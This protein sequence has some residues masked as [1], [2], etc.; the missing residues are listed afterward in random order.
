MRALPCGRAG[1]LVELGT[2]DEVLALYAALVEHP[3]EGVLDIV[4]AA[5]T[6]LLH[7]DPA[8]T[9]PAQLERTVRAVEPRRGQRPAGELVEL[10]VVYDGPDLQQVGNLTGWGAYGV[11]ERH[12]GRE[13]T[14]AFCGFVPGFGYLTCPGDEWAIPRLDSPRTRV[15]VGS[16][17]LAGE[18]SAVY[19]S[20]TPGGWQL[21][22]RTDATLF[23]LNRDP[24]ALLT[25]G[26]RVR[27][28]DTGHGP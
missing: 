26:T 28:V 23:D 16:V 6:V 15:P 21:I 1:L 24:P 18:F 14:V 22:G 7:V 9:D 4:P 19:P 10:P 5:R 8:V 17:A 13:W 27:F 25:P 11:V 12:T 2:L 3:P 20:D